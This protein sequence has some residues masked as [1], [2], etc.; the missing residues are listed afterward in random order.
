MNPLAGLVG[1]S[2]QVVVFLDPTFSTHSTVSG[3]FVLAGATVGGFGPTMTS[4]TANGSFWQWTG[5]L[6][7]TIQAG[8]T[9]T[10]SVS[11]ND[12]IGSP[13]SGFAIFTNGSATHNTQLEFVIPAVT[14]DPFQTPMSVTAT[15]ASFKLTGKATEGTGAPYSVS[16]VQVQIGN[17][18]FANVDAFTAGNAITWSAQVSIPNLGSTVI[19]VRASDPYGASATTQQTITVLQYNPITGPA[20]KTIDRQLPTTSSVTSW[21]RLEP[22]VA[23]ADIGVSSNARVF[24]PLWMMTRQ[25]QM[26]EF[27]GEDAGTPVQA[28][29]RATTASLSRIRF[30]EPGSANA[31]TAAY[32]PMTLPLETAIERRATRAASSADL[33]ALPLRV[34][35]GLHFLHMLSQATT[36]SQDYTAFARTHWALAAL[37]PAQ[38]AA[39]DDETRRFVLMMSNRALDADRLAEFIRSAAAG[40]LQAALGPL[41]VASVDQTLLANTMQAWL[42]WYDQLFSEG[43]DLD[44]WTAPRLEYATSIAAHGPTASANGVTL[45]AYEFDGGR[46]DWSSFD[47]DP[48]YPI[49]TSGDAVGTPLNQRSVPV[50]VT[51]AG[52]PAPRFWEMEDA[53][54]AYGLVPVGPTDLAHLMMIEYASSYGNDWYLVPVDIPVGSL[55]QVDSLVVTDTFGVRSLIRPIGDPALSAPHFSMWQQAGIRRAGDPVDGTVG[56]PVRNLFFL[57]PTLNNSLDGAVI[58]DVLFM[59]DEMA[60][61]AWAIERSIESGMESSFSLPTNANVPAPAPASTFSQYLLSSTVPA[62]WIP[63]LPVEIDPTLGLTRLQ[64]GAVLQPDGSGIPHNAQSDTLKG[65]GTQLLYDEEVPREGVHITRRRRMTRWMDGS[66]WAWTANRND[67]GTGEGSAGLEFDQLLPSATGGNAATTPTISAQLSVDDVVLNGAATP[68]T[69]TVNNPGP[70]LAG[71][72]LQ[73]WLTQDDTR[74]AAGGMLVNLGGGTAVLPNGTGTISGTIIATN[75]GNGTGTLAL[76]S[77]LFEL[78]LKVG[79]KVLTTTTVPVTVV[80]QPTITALTPSAPSAYIDGLTTPYTATLENL[81]PDLSGMSLQG[82]VTQGTARRTAGVAAV[83]CGSGA[84]VLPNGT[85]N[86]SGT[87][88]ATNGGTGTGTLVPGAATFELQLLDGTGAELNSITAAVTL[89]PNTPV[90]SAPTPSTTSVIITGTPT[91]YSTTLTNPGSSRSNV[92]LQGF[93]NQ[94]TA[95]RDAGALTLNVGSGAGVL[96][97]GLSFPV[98]GSIAASNTSGGTGTLV[99]GAA[100]FELQLLA[101]GTSLGS[102]TAPVTLE[103][104]TP[105]IQS[106]TPDTTPVTIDGPFISYSAVVKNPGASVANVVLQGSLSQGTTQHAAGGATIDCGAGSGVLP[107]GIFT[108]GG[109]LGAS[110]NPNS[111]SGTF[112]PGPATFLLQLKVNGSIVYSTT[113]TVTLVRPSISAVNPVSTSVIIDASSVAYTATV[114]N[115]A[116]TIPAATILALIHQGSTQRTASSVS[117]GDLANGSAQVSDKIVASNTASGTGTLVP[118]AATVELQVVANGTVLSSTTFNITLQAKPTI[119]AMTLQSSTV[120]LGATSTSYQ[121]SFTNPGSSLSNVALQGWIS[122]GS[123][124]HCAVG[125]FIDFGNGSGVLPNGSGTLSAPFGAFNTTSGTGTLA[126][127]AATFE[128]QLTQGTELLATTTLPV[129]VV[130]CPTLTAPSPTSTNVI[131]EGPGVPYTATLNNTGPS[132]PNVSINC[133]VLQGAASRSS[134]TA[135]TDFGNGAG[136]APA[137]ATALSSSILASNSQAGTGTLVAGPATVQWTVLLFNTFTLDTKTVNVLLEPKPTITALSA[138][139]DPVAIDGA[140]ATTFTSTL[141]NQGVSLSGVTLQGAIIQGSARRAAGAAINVDCG[142]GAGVLPTGSFAA[143]GPITASNTSTGNGTL[144]SGAATF[145]LDLIENGV[146]LDTK[147]AAVTLVPNTPAIVSVT[148]TTTSVLIGGPEVLYT[149]TLR[150]PGAGLTG[151]ALQN[152]LIQTATPNAAGGALIST[153]AG[154]GVLPTG[155]STV[156]SGFVTSTGSYVAGAATL[157]VELIQSGNVLN[158]TTVP[159]TLVPKPTVTTVAPTS[160]TLAL[161]GQAV[162]YTVTIQNP[163]PAL[164]NMTLTST[165]KQGTAQRQAGT[166]SDFSGNHLVVPN[167]ASVGSGQITASNSGAGSGTLVAGAATLAVSLTQSNIELAAASIPITLNLPSPT[168]NSVTPIDSLLIEGAGAV[169]TVT[170]ANPGASLSNVSVQFFLEQKGAKRA[171]GTIA[172]FGGASGVL[173]TGTSSGSVSVAASNASAGSG[174][175]AA[176]AATLDV[177]LL[178]NGTV[179]DTKIA[180]VTLQQG[181]INTPPPA[182]A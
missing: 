130:P 144:V 88:G 61:V 69:V 175:L 117:L 77:A 6:P 127:G 115:S 86:V 156:S 125:P 113:A 41:G 173:P 64:R 66:S 14:I 163:G 141:A 38:D 102:Q 131:V 165:I 65:L 80:H 103:P 155:T 5:L 84:G 76:G 12:V 161:E 17:G 31:R 129:T 143:T 98:S 116:G 109:S 4:S 35:A 94:G 57:P 25:W 123:A 170:L 26:G 121:T 47:V 15:P 147:T 151:V 42:A 40:T 140:S 119:A 112:V 159:V 62:N 138:T 97:T 27:Q 74:R 8:Q 171:A 19:T 83:D 177:Q 132:L 108:V 182:G 82:F 95:R 70:T 137:G 154:V 90:F 87:I 168:I 1:R 56:N 105:W 99:P 169:C 58:E 81:G 107:T 126:P 45:S 13:D 162:A 29:L 51:F 48:T 179:A 145:E 93:L 30:G 72:S 100:T 178:V 124:R 28:R 118:G 101:N 150:N 128:L 9:F 39:T 110:S 75:T 63:L 133:L 44:A 34:E 96:P 60:N 22:V 135:I 68:Y 114:T 10:I 92:V 79:A 139:S 160:S 78:Q 142:S 181:I 24:D 21:T 52:A 111:G 50:P 158:T 20:K 149:A 59:R 148:P 67:V 153:G 53:K 164:S 36:L 176:G 37:T 104:N 46:L 167:G 33:R 54:V 32:N 91:S 23:Q 73:G 3:T 180:Q 172:V 16:Q 134:G 106:L 55:T 2:L 152:F 18:P 89:A 157:Q 43:T 122:Q 11:A 71:V 146:V 174:T 85:F 166:I 49:D 136:I 120:V 7:N